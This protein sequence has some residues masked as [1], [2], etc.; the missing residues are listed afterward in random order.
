MRESEE[1][2]SLLA[3]IKKRYFLRRS[4]RLL[5][6]FLDLLLLS[7]LIS[8]VLRYLQIIESTD[9]TIAGVCF[10]VALFSSVIYILKTRKSTKEVL[11]DLDSRLNLD[12]R[13]ITTFEYEF[14]PK[15]S[16]YKDRLTKDAVNSIKL[17]EPHLWFPWRLTPAYPA[18]LILGILLVTSIYYNAY[19]GSSLQTTAPPFF[20]SFNLNKKGEGRSIEK[21][22]AEQK[23]QG[24]KK[25]ELKAFIQSLEES[26]LDTK[27][28]RLSLESILNRIAVEKDHV[29][30][31]IKE[32][33]TRVNPTDTPE[34]ESIKENLKSGRNPGQT[35]SH[36]QEFQKNNRN[37]EL[38]DN[39][40]QLSELSD[41]EKF[42]EDAISELDTKEPHSPR[43]KK[44]GQ[45]NPE[46]EWTENEKDDSGDATEG[47]EKE[48]GGL[49]VK[50]S[51]GKETKGI[52]QKDDEKGPRSGS[53]NK[54]DPGFS[55]AP[56]KGKSTWEKAYGEKM[57]T[58]PSPTRK[59]EGKT[60][61]GERYQSLVR[62]LTAKGQPVKIDKELLR[63]YEKDVTSVLRREEIPIRYRNHIKRYFLSIGLVQGTSEED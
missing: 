55:T 4:E 61:E 25:E 30:D 26:G 63:S 62:S 51:V 41:M 9:L 29:I 2:L 60:G 20:E 23:K 24:K 5:L 13:L 15:K 40:Q 48:G 12:E 46:S 43:E 45:D 16:L 38:G 35:M 39:I 10:P 22:N 21:K 54:V 57:K 18:I 6:V 37:S 59:L 3:E 14:P 34:T 52:R 53:S 17:V 56:G 44:D 58:N 47:E 49:S 28:A 50:K 32:N 42:L 31:R 19:L 7:F 11:I 27:E 8:Q 33:M 36:L 1:F